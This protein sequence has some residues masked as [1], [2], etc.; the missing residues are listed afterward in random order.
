MKHIIPIFALIYLY[1]C[2]GPLAG[3]QTR[4]VV[5]CPSR[6]LVPSG[7]MGDSA[8]SGT[9]GALDRHQSYVTTEGGGPDHCFFIKVDSRTF[10][11]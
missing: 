11:F 9:M 1:G 3:Q 5:E 4:S 8:A 10:N 7:E 2:H 6:S